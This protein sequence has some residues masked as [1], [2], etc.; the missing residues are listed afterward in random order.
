MVN[1]FETILSELE[2][3]NETLSKIS[4]P[5]ERPADEI[6]DTEELCQRLAISEPTAIRWR[7]RKKIPFFTIGTSV[8]YNWPK[9]VA[10]FEN[11]SIK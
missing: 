9:V 11:Q 1:P 5:Q 4:L 3:I 7:K 2:K 6:I 10:Q 8:R